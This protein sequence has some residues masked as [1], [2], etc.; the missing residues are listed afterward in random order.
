MKFGAVAV[1]DL[2]D[3]AVAI[4]GEITSRLRLTAEGAR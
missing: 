4:M 2:D 1:A 3:S